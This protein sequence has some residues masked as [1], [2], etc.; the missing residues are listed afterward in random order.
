MTTPRTGRET[1]QS[2]R[3]RKSSPEGV[4]QGAKT[5]KKRSGNAH[6]EE[7]PCIPE[8]IRKIS[9]RRRMGFVVQG[10]CLGIL[11]SCVP[12]EIRKRTGRDP[13]RSRPETTSGPSGGACD[14][15]GCCCCCVV[16]VFCAIWRGPGERNVGHARN[17]NSHSARM[18]ILCFRNPNFTKRNS[19][20]R[21]LC[22]GTNRKSSPEGRLSD[23]AIAYGY[24]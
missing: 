18:R 22:S 13:E 12:E 10:R 14:M 20:R 2:G 3:I 17:A 4:G 11:R 19:G 5:N 1:Q 24:F 9:G 6:P 21:K 7:K 8:E 15:A 16:A 23:Y